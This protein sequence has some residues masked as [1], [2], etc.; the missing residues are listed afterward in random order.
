MGNGRPEPVLQVRERASHLPI[1]RQRNQEDDAA[2]G[3]RGHLFMAG[4]AACAAQG[5]SAFAQL[6]LFASQQ[7]AHDFAAEVAG[8][9]AACC[10]AHP[11]NTT[12]STAVYLLRR[13]HGDRAAKDIAIHCRATDA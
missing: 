4:V 13:A 12:A 2:H 5:V 10:P 7:Q 6:W 9:Q 1:P 3:Q 8:V 11:A